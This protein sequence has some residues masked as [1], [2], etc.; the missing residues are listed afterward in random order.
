ML[1]VPHLKGVAHINS[2]S[3]IEHPT[4]LKPD[5]FRYFNNHNHL[6]INRPAIQHSLCV[7]FYA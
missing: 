4:A 3:K 6:V 7:L 5:I 2:A 1:R